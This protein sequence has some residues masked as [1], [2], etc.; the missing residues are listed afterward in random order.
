MDGQGG[1]VPRADAKKNP[2]PGLRSISYLGIDDGTQMA[3]TW[4]GDRNR[5]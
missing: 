3:Y 2:L 5:L 1:N 4:D